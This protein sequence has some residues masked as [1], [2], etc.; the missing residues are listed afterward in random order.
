MDWDDE[1][2]NEYDGMDYAS[3]R[4]AAV[5]DTGSE[6]GVDP[7]NIADSASSYFLLSDDAQDEITGS[8][9][10]KMECVSCGH[11]FVGEFYDR[12]PRVLQFGYRGSDLCEKND[13]YW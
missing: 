10:K 4:D 1:F 12:C 2:D 7:M 13:G 9:K 8:D 6:G 11:R 5:L 3:H